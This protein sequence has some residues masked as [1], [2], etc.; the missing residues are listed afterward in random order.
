LLVLVV[1]PNPALDRVAL[2]PRARDGGTVRA[3]RTLE[4]AGGKALHAARV[5]AALGANVRVIAPL[6]GESGENVARR[7]DES[8]I[9]LLRVPIGESTRCTFTVVDDEQ[10]DMLEII[11]PSPRLTPDEVALLRSRVAAALSGVGV[12]VCAGS[13]PAG[14]ET[15]FAGWLV[16]RARAAGATSIVDASGAVLADALAAR[17]DL[18]TPNLAEASEVTGCPPGGGASA[19]AAVLCGR[20]ARAAL[21]TDGPRGGSLAVAGADAEP[22]HWSFDAPSRRVVNAVGCGDAVVGG[23]AAGFA[24]GLHLPDAVV[25]GVAAAADKVGRLEGGHIERR[26]AEAAV[27]DVGMHLLGR[28][29][30]MSHPEP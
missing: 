12:V 15:T 16:D 20:G 6:G 26:A 7:L 8:P 27:S 19:A 23:I 3:T 18:V 17:P 13:V 10:G 1:C 30:A 29:S 9:E 14:V 21:V 22:A 11:D 28:S 24:R 25:L 2:G 4:E 5:A